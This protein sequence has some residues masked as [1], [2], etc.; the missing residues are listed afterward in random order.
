VARRAVPVLVDLVRLEEAPGA[1]DPEEL[2]AVDE[3]VVDAVTLAVARRSCRA[4]HDVVA[5]AIA[6]GLALAPEE[7]VD[8]RILPDTGRPRDDDQQ[9]PGCTLDDEIRPTRVAPD[10]QL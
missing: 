7:R 5:L 1:V 10:G 6:T 9:R 3:L 4:G 8:D 2:V